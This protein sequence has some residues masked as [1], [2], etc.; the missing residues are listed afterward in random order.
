MADSRP[1]TPAWLS[2]HPSAQGWLPLDFRRPTDRAT[3]ATN[4]KKRRISDSFCDVVATQQR[5]LGPCAARDESVRRLRLEG[6]TVVAT[7]QQVG[8]FL[9]PLYTLHKAASAIAWAQLVAA[10]SGSA[11]VPVFWLQTEDHDLAEIATTYFPGSTGAM[12][13]GMDAQRQGDAALRSVRSCVFDSQVDALNARVCELLAGLPYAEDVSALLARHYREGVTWPKA[14]AGVLAEVFAGTGLLIFDPSDPAVVPFAAPVH[15]AAFVHRA[16]IASSLGDRVAALQQAG[17][18]VQVHVRADAPLFFWHPEGRDGPRYRIEPEQQG[19][20]TTWRLC[21]TDV[22]VTQ[23]RIERDLADNT[24][25]FSTS[26]LLRP[27]LQDVLFPTVAHIGGPGE[28]AYF[29]QILPLYKQLESSLSVF[30]PLIVARH[31]FYLLDASVRRLSEQ[32]DLS[33]RDALLGEAAI[34]ARWG[35]HSGEGSGE[36]DDEDGGHDGADPIGRELGDLKASIAR[37]LQSASEDAGHW[38]RSL[39]KAADRLASQI[40]SQLERFTD[41]RHRAVASRDEIRLGRLVRWLAALQPGGVPQER[42]YGFASY[43]ARVG[44]KS[45]VDQL[46][47]SA[48]LEPDLGA[49]AKG[50]AIWL[51]LR[52]ESPSEVTE[53]GESDDG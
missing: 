50:E 38:D 7:G 49:V 24:G 43:A 14:F 11:C 19:D 28:C 33:G 45:L 31:R 51:E 52:A 13:V 10:E 39:A 3:A 44:I 6:T 40:A 29:A 15:R 26:A 37:T 8:L 12:A 22:V 46:L 27:L 53:Q 47:L 9:G 21:G 36:A 2:D 35:R 20:P 48:A 32:L 1:F 41:R 4:A 23:A 5:Q 17:I 30:M 34:L 16:A 42:V 18:N 25:C